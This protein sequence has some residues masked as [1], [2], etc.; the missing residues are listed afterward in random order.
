MPDGTCILGVYYEGQ[1]RAWGGV[2]RSAD[3]GKSWNGPMTI[4]KESGLYLDAE[5]DTVLLEDGTLYAALRHRGNMHYATS[6]DLGLTW[7]PVKDIGFNAHAPH[8][9]R[10][11]SGRILLSHR[12][13]PDGIKANGVTALH[14][15][16]D[17][18]RTWEPYIVDSCLGA[19][20]STVEL[21]DGSVLI[22]YYEEGNRG[23]APSAIRAQRFKLTPEGLK[24]LPLD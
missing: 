10:L 16:H 18:A 19:Y 22:V 13:L 2:L 1:G 8:F 15:S 20:P 4:G 3:S 12:F 11:R 17:E 21:A 24:R 9:T 6:T 5:T 14:V 23:E 7:S